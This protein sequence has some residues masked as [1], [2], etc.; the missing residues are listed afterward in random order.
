MKRRPAIELSRHKGTTGA[1][2]DI[3]VD[4]DRPVLGGV[5][6]SRIISVLGRD[7]FGEFD[8]VRVPGV[9]AWCNFGLARELGFSVG[10]RDRMTPRLHDELIHALSF[11]ALQPG[12]SA[13]ASQTIRLYADKYGGGGVSPALGSA[14]SGFLPYGNLFLKGIG[15]TPLFRHKDKDDFA[16]SHGW[17]PMAEALFEAVLGEVNNNLL[18]HRS[19]RVLAI[20]DQHQEIVY[21]DGRRRPSGIAV[22][23]G[24]Q[25]RPGHVMAPRSG[26][27]RSRTEIF[28][29]I[30]SETGQQAIC[31]GEPGRGRHSADLHATMLRIVDDHAAAASELYR[32]RLVHGALSPSNM[33]IGG[34]MLD[35][36]DE[37]SQIRTAPIRLI[38]WDESIYGIEQ[39]ERGRQLASMYGLLL[40]GMSKS[41][42][43]ALNGR[44]FDV[45]SASERAYDRNIPIRVL[46]AAGFRPEVAAEINRDHPDV[47]SRLAQTIIAM[48]SLRNPGSINAKKAPVEKV[49]VLDV[50]NLLGTFPAEFFSAPEKD[51]CRAIRAALK[52]IH[53]G[54]HFHVA[55]RKAKVERLIAD[56]AAIYREIMFVS[57]PLVRR[58]YGDFTGMRKSVVA[59]AAFENRPIPLICFST[60]FQEANRIVAQHRDKI[61]SSNF[62]REVDYLISAS[63]RNGGDL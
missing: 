32:W 43:Q 48:A 15:K 54:N 35:L 7:M 1:G 28:L 22:R 51:H 41:D 5:G 40:R 14:R 12:E 57:K 60:L 24:R 2:L 42:R 16:H 25:L 45:V 21:P 30:T 27:D 18:S 34:G 52:P 47:S 56:F 62:Q 13:E 59:R 17:L 61:D 58:Y 11:R 4:P 10:Q 33:E 37:S 44:A 20:I 49:A 3:G 9:V 26:G 50:F 8:A 38:G 31:D 53:S 29:S 6:A 46:E 39:I 55:S 63:L 23:S 19:T 36:A